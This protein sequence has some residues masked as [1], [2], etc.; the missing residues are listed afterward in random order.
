MASQ[1]EPI[2]GVVIVR[3]SEETRCEGL[4]VR[5]EWYTR[6]AGNQ[7]KGEASR[8]ALYSGAWWPGEHRYRFSIA[9]P[10][11]PLSSDTGPLSVR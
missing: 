11:G 5:C 2:A 1:G 6:G 3:V 10:L 7:E 4:A 9:A 8:E